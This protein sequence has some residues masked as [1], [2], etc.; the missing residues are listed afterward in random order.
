[1][2]CRAD[3]LKLLLAN[4]PRQAT[5]DPYT[6]EEAERLVST[7]GPEWRPFLLCALRTGLRLG[8]LRALEWGDIDW[9]NRFIRVER[10]FVE[11]EFTTP[12]NGLARNVDLSLQ[13]RATLRLWRRQRRAAW[14]AVG[15]AATAGV[16]VGR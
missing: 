2:I 9:R 16:S 4:A 13:L 14:M 10:N 15:P 8:E 12:K 6:R 11:R 3:Y 7:A 1:V 5:I